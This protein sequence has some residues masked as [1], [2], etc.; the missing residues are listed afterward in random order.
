MKHSKLILNC[1]PTILIPNPWVILTM[2]RH[3]PS[4]KF[5]WK[6]MQC[7]ISPDTPRT[8]QLQRKSWNLSIVPAL[9]SW[10]PLWHSIWVMVTEGSEWVTVIHWLENVKVDKIFFKMLGLTIA[11]SRTILS[12]SN[13]RMLKISFY[14]FWVWINGSLILHPTMSSAEKKQTTTK[15]QY[16]NYKVSIISWFLM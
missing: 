1:K 5:C 8:K 4:S 15:P 10:M 16:S 11:N 9:F 6:P 13:R 12:S 7:G 2:V 14:N 3:A